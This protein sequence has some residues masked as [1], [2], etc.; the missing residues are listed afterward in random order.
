MKI[1]LNLD[2]R[3]VPDRGY[4]HL[5]TAIVTGEGVGYEW[6]GKRVLGEFMKPFVDGERRTESEEEHRFLPIE[7]AYS[8]DELKA[9]VNQLADIE[10]VDSG[11][12]GQLGAHLEEIGRSMSK[13][14]LAIRDE[15]TDREHIAKRIAAKAEKE[16]AREI[17][18][19]EYE[20]AGVKRGL[21]T[22]KSDEFCDLAI[23]DELR[24]D[25]EGR[26]MPRHYS[27]AMDAFADREPFST[28]RNTHPWIKL[29]VTEIDGT[30]VK[31]QVRANKRVL[32][33][34]VK[35]LAD[36]DLP[37]RYKPRFVFGN[38]RGAGSFESM[39]DGDDADEISDEVWHLYHL[40]DGWGE[41]Y[42]S[43][44]WVP[45]DASAWSDYVSTF[46]VSLKSVNKRQSDQ[47]GYP[48]GTVYGGSFRSNG[49]LQI[50]VFATTTEARLEED[51]GS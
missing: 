8:N 39:V 23:G 27:P 42:R 47:F 32:D 44:H 34:V 3:A 26:R 46:T 40:E 30:D 19:W 51:R 24:F 29:V 9:I 5:D 4:N 45:A 35:L 36:G 13:L 10:F 7:D 15:R 18:L 14:S 20:A 33:S 12:L 43:N 38:H 22:T 1:Q 11:E 48:V 6:E 49:G 41:L 2:T 17:S 16:A 25:G 28:G 21:A 37:R 50:A 31:C